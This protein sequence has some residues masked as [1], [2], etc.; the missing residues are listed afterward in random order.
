MQRPLT[1]VR[2]VEEITDLLRLVEAGDAKASSQLFEIVYAKLKAM[3]RKRLGGR[4]LELDATSLVHET[5]MRLVARGQLRLAD[6]AA[7]YAYV[8][9]VMR[10]VVI[11]HVRAQR[12]LKRAGEL[13]MVTLVSGVAGDTF[14][15][16]QL[17]ALNTALERLDQLAPE[18]R[19]LLDMRYFAGLSIREIAEMRGLST[20]TVEREWEKARAFL[21]ALMK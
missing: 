4:A 18:M 12:A 11:D 20:R 6:R 13:N 19:S 8:G 3:A 14:E 1:E 16:A 9:R 17:I 21:L 15:D 7:F 10:S 2:V 5:Y